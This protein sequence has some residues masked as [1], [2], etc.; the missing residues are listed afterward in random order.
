MI[1]TRGTHSSGAFSRGNN[2]PA[3]A[4]PLGFNFWIPVTDAGSTSWVYE[5]HRA[6]N[7]D[8]LAELQAFAV[9]H[10]T[11][12]WMGDRQ[13]FQVLPSDAT[14]TPDADEPPGPCRSGTRTRPPGPTTTR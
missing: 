11:S 6:N 9:S 2:I 3:T 7:A 10:Q 12:P 14:G 13:T 4:L 8:N 5:Y 1:T